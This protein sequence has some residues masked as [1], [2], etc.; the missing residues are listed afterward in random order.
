MILLLQI[1]FRLN[2]VRLHG[3][4]LKPLVNKD[5]SK[6]I[7]SISAVCSDQKIARNDIKVAAKIISNLDR[8]HGLWVDAD[9]PLLSSAS[10]YLIDEIAA[11]EEELLSKAVDSTET[12]ENHDTAGDLDVN[13]E[14]LKVLDKLILYLRIVHSTDYY[15]SGQ[16]PLE[17]E[18]PNRLG[19]L[20]VRETLDRGLHLSGAEADR[21]NTER[22]LKL[23]HLTRTPTTL[24][25][26]EAAK[27]GEAGRIFWL[28]LSLFIA[29][30]KL[31]SDEIEKFVS[32]NCQEISKDKWLCPLSG[33]KFKSPEFIKKHILNKFPDR[34]EKVKLETEFYN[35][36]IRD[37]ARP[38]LPER[39][40]KPVVQIKPTERHLTEGIGVSM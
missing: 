3:K 38:E 34:V 36:Y 24:Q 40:N 16:Y 25:G 7:R 15:S 8:K 27:L 6:R 9:N 11:E 32:S 12:V 2:S 19:L 26:E 30:L 20:H 4:D 29:G 39:P 35:N 21:L 13:E 17:D 22:G 5:L 18:M 10:D 14:V 37:P 1:C 23:S 28:D 31:E 33:K